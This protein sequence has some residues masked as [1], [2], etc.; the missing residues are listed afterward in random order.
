MKSLLTIISIFFIFS[1]TQGQE[2]RDSVPFQNEIFE[3]IYS[4][5]LEQPI[6]I[7]YNVFCFSPNNVNYTM[8]F[9][10]E[11]DI[12]TSD[13]KDYK[14]NIWDKGHMVPSADFRCSEGF[15]DLT[16]S[17]LN[18]ALQHQGLNRGKWR[19]LEAYERKLAEN[20]F[21][22]VH[23]E[24]DIHFSEFCKKTAGGATIPYGFTKHIIVNNEP[25]GCF[26]F[27][28]EYAPRNLIYYKVDCKYH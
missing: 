16:Y 6:W 3:G 22:D 26:F 21:D 15:F 18:C 28:N 4:E 7:S 12:H 20:I 24:I 23:V 13:N 11:S 5:V 19:V 17:Y 2:L 14:N 25:K 9:Y 1:L 8:T 10:K 27:I